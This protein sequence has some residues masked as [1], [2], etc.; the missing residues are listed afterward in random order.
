M[1]MSPNPGT[2]EI[3]QDPMLANP[4]AGDFHLT[5]GSPA[6]DAGNP[7]PEFNDPDGTRG[8]MGAL[9][10]HQDATSVASDGARAAMSWGAMKD[11]YR[12]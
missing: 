8:D 5:R 1:V 6:I 10:F 7:A 2:G 3:H 9:Y 11:R 4:G 12:R